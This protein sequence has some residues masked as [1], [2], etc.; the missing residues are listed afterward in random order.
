MSKIGVLPISSNTTITLNYCPEFLVVSAVD[1]ANPVSSLT[2]TVDGKVY[3]NLNTQAAITALGKIGGGGLLGA[4][5]ALGSIFRL[6]TGRIS[7]ATT[8]IQLTNADATAYDVLGFSISQDGEP[9]SV[10]QSTVQ[11]SSDIS[12]DEFLGLAFPET[13]VDRLDVEFDNGFVESMTVAEV[14]AL[15]MLQKGVTDA[16]GEAGTYTALNGAGLES[17]TIFN[18]NGGSTLVINQF[19]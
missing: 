5:V 1:L 11:A 2:V 9:V 10:A 6:A 7:N 14:K 4:D 17:V 15:F 19:I 8:Q 18:G 3:Q 12:F 16:D 13:N